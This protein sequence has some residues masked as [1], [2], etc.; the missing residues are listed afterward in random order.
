VIVTQLVTQAWLAP[1]PIGAVQEQMETWLTTIAPRRVRRSTL[2]S[3]YAPKVRKRIIP[4]LG[5]HRLDRLTPEHVEHFYTTLEAEGL[6]PATVLQIHR[7]LSRALKVATQRGYVGRNV[8]TLVDAPS[9]TQSE[10]EPL[11]ATSV[12][13]V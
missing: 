2:E 6:V 10:I 11:T 1:Y 8:A 12:I 5:K 13:L 9:V 4:G 3:T 7:M